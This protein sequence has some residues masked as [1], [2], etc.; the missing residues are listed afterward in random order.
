[1]T[2]YR[3]TRLGVATGFVAL[4]IGQVVFSAVMIGG[5]VVDGITG[6]L[7]VWITSTG[8]IGM[9]LCGF[10]QRRL[11]GRPIFTPEVR[12][13]D[14]IVG[15]PT[16]AAFVLLVVGAFQHGSVF[17]APVALIAFSVVVVAGF[18]VE[19]VVIMWPRPREDRA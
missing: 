3:D 1:M 6:H 13:A 2:V 12:T 14:A 15:V 18:T 4:A 7:V 19:R 8:I 16:A 5:L 11:Y 9:S 10:V 17:S